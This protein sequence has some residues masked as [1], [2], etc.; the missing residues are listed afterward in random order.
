MIVFTKI[1][2]NDMLFVYTTIFGVIVFGGELCE[3]SDEE[4]RTKT[5]VDVPPGC[6]CRSALTAQ[7]IS[8]LELESIGSLYSLWICG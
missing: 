5:F 8:G 2:I 3:I 7:G 1:V 4:N 6:I